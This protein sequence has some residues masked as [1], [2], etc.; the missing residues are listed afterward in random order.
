VRV[1]T[2]LITV[3]L[4]AL[5]LAPS[6]VSAQSVTAPDI[7]LTAEEIGPDWTVLG[8]DKRQAAGTEIARVELASPS[9]RD[10]V[11][12]TGVAVSTELAEALITY[13]QD[14]FGT[15]GGDVQSV[16]SKGFGDGRAFRSQYIDGAHRGVMYLFRVRNLVTIVDYSGGSSA[17][18]VPQQAEALAR[19][20]EGK[21]FAVFAPKPLATPTPAPLAPVPSTPTPVPATPTPVAQPQIAEVP[22]Q[23][24]CAPGEKPQ[25]RF[26]FA[27]LST[28][29]SDTMG[30]AT[31]CEYADPRG[32]GDTL[33]TTEHGLGI[34]RQG[35]DT[36]TFTNGSDHWAL[37]PDG[38]V[39]W[40]GDTVD[41]PTDAT[42]IP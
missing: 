19:K 34:Y 42:L 27:T 8:R 3:A 6:L 33:Q 5:V 7:A 31:S 38:L 29:L 18:D 9:G 15:Y 40:S 35:S 14:V 25:F 10:V 17:N 26:G 24:Y 41:P 12:T 4:S 16:Q 28:R 1:I 21:L 30:K 20:Q 2:F 23:P 39:Y 11:I 37:V 13:L 36:P 22:T 32:S